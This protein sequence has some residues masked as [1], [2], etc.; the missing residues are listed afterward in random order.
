[1]LTSHARAQNV[2]RARDCGANLVLAKPIS[3]KMIYDR[4]LWI[5][6]DP[7]PFVLTRSYIGP[8]RRFKEG[9]PLGAADRRAAGASA[10]VS[11]A[12]IRVAPMRAPALAH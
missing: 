7:R 11:A 1:M 5:A 2:E 4:L 6:E 10:D 9:P 3:P 8:D 12:Q